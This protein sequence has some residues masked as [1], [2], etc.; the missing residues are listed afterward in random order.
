MRH[1][2]LTGILYFSSLFIV[3]RAQHFAPV[4]TYSVGTPASNPRGI[5]TG[6]LDRD[7]YAD[8]VTAN[9]ASRQ[10]GV[11][12]NQRNGTFAPVVHYALGTDNS[13]YDIT[14]GD[15]NQ[16]GYPDVATANYT[17][18]T[19]S[20]LLNKQ[21]GTL[22]PPVM[23]AIAG[24]NYPQS[25]V[26][27]DV[28]RDGYPD[29]VAANLGNTTISVF[30]NRRDGTFAFP[31]SY[32]I[33]PSSLS[34]SL[35][36]GDLNQDGYID[37]I[38]ACYCPTDNSV[39]VLLNQRDGT[40]AALVRYPLAVNSQP[41]GITVGD[42]NGDSYVDVVT[43]NLGNNTVGV[44]LNQQN[45]TLG[46][47][48]SYATGSGSQPSSVALADVDGNNQP[49]MVGSNIGTST[50]GLLIQR[51]DGQFSATTTYSTGERSEPG[52]M[53]VVDVNKDGRVDILTANS[54]TGTVGVLLS[55][56]PLTS[57]PSRFVRPVTVSFYPNPT[58]SG[59]PFVIAMTKL[60][61]AARFLEITFS[62][63]LGQLVAR[64]TVAVND[65]GQVQLP[66]P[67]LASG[68]YLVRIVNRA[69]DYTIV[70]VTSAR[71]LSV[72]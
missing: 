16:D 27:A 11:L 55:Q 42:V 32:P 8:I 67:V 6:D 18:Q 37:I 56:L 25:L 54:A 53:A 47:A 57:L 41:Y 69:A 5:A 46:P 40:F 58:T 71:W 49:D 60:P 26:A 7:G 4:I 20:V 10:V 45:G 3:V 70:G 59:R 65:P 9:Y 43:A 12:L 62:N 14:I 1:K 72:Q 63:S 15:F 36:V 30:I 17:S 48:L 66:T 22:A 19:V 2:L 39:G 50:V 52:R 44:L 13:P 23:Y 34:L 33:A 51:P 29:L 64:S 38:T 21:D 68:L 24:D 31:N 28:N 61:Q 35:A